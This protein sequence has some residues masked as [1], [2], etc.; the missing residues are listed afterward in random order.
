MTDVLMKLSPFRNNR[1]VLRYS[2]SVGDIMSGI[3]ETHKKY[4]K[5]YDLICTK[6]DGATAEI[7]AH[8]V[9][10]FL[11]RHTFYV[12]EAD[13]KQTLRSPAAILALGANPKVGLDCKSY[14]LF[15]GGIL[16]AFKR[17]GRKIDWCYRFASYRLIDKV[18]H[19]VFVVLNPSTNNEIWVDPVLP[20]FN[21]KK[22]YNYKIDK[23]INMALIAVAG[24]GKA[25]RTK[26]EKAKR[27]EELKAKLKA[28]IKKRGKLLLK[29]NP[30]TAGARNAI[31]LVIKINLFGLAHKLFQLIKKPNGEAKLK[32]F[33][34]SIGGRYAS[35][36]K[37]I[38]QGI[39][40]GK[41]KNEDRILAD[42]NKTS[43]TATGPIQYAKRRPNVGMAIGVADPVTASAVVASTPILIKLITMLKDMGIDTDKLGKAAKD[44]LKK[45]VNDKI[46]KF[47]DDK[48]NK[49]EGSNDTNYNSQG[50][51]VPEGDSV[52]NAE[53]AT[54]NDEGQSVEGIPTNKLLIGAAIIGSAYLL[55]KKK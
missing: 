6:F 39:K 47:A 55:L 22:Q 8:K 36:T 16:D 44:V 26:A 7:I 40:H 50:I 52:E 28:S 32:K 14:S 41:H 35:L 2:Q 11:K 23:K 19:H 34:E 24:I 30:A 13:S 12:V 43:K 21:N 29:F 51:P 20:S 46:D 25:K 1:R 5:E 27:R 4:A 9:Y 48:A 18:P 31:L 53:E 45:A 37:N 38:Q 54:A 42:L 33:W 15:I 3:L 49:E 17:R 10:N